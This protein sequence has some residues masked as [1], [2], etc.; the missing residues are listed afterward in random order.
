MVNP[1]V[2]ISKGSEL[3]L[4]VSTLKMP[5]LLLE[6]FTHKGLCSSLEVSTPQWLSC[7]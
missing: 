2:S 6:V 7:I 4:D 3:Q 5:V 1:E